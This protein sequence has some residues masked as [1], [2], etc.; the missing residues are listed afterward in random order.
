MVSCGARTNKP[1]PKRIEFM[2]EIVF[3]ELPLIKNVWSFGLKSSDFDLDLSPND[4]TN[5][6]AAVPTDTI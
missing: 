6:R 3:G 5:F 1:E 4:Q 2:T